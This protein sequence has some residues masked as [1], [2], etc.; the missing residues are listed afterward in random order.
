M[1]APLGRILL[2]V[3][4]G[5]VLIAGG[6]GFEA[7]SERVN[8]LSAQPIHALGV[9]GIAL[10]V[11]FLASAAISFGISYKLGLIEPSPRTVRPELPGI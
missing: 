7:V 8:D 1:G 5:V 4:A 2:S 11:G 6:I 10:G 9:L 3:Q